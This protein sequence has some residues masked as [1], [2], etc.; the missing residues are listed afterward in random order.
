MEID[1]LKLY[2]GIDYPV[3]TEFSIHT[4]TIEEITRYGE[5]DFYNMA[6]S[7]VMEPVDM[8]WQL[9]DQGIDWTKVDKF[10]FFTDIIAPTLTNDMTKIIF[11]KYLDFSKMV[12]IYDEK[13][14]E[15]VLIQDIK[16]EFDENEEEHS[17]KESLTFQIRID[18][19]THA[20]IKEIMRETYGFAVR[21]DKPANEVTKIAQIEDE[22]D[23]YME[24]KDK[25]YKSTL[26]NYISAMVNSAEFKHDEKS[27]FKMNIYAFMNSV[28][29]INKIKN[30]TLLLQSGYSGFG[31][32]LKDISK[33]E[34]DWVG[35][36]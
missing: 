24:N 9:W 10:Q 29:R 22:K 32:S 15:Y 34:L 13:I 28:R 4:P 5:K 17:D 1:K 20:L 3:T 14:D 2:M 31:V 6:Y 21:T 12:K 18:R 8:K 19:Y 11:G 7:V 30:A 35:D 16:L 33:D 27:V 36:V 26:F 25:P 23:E